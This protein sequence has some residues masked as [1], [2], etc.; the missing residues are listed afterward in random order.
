MQTPLQA[1]FILL[2][3]FVL[4]LFFSYLYQFPLFLGA[5]LWGFIDL[6]FKGDQNFPLGTFHNTHGNSRNIYQRVNFDMGF[7][8]RNSFGGQSVVCIFTKVFLFYLLYHFS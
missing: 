5:D 7:L 2:V 1:N 4:N 6:T 3:S 8:N